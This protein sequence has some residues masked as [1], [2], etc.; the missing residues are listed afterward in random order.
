MKFCSGCGTALV[1]NLEKQRLECPKCGAEEPI[2]RNRLLEEPVFDK[3]AILYAGLDMDDRRR[4]KAYLD[5]LGHYA[6]WDVLRLDL[7]GEPLEPVTRRARCKLDPSMLKK[8]AEKY[9]IEPSK[10]E[11]LLED[12]TLD[13]SV[14]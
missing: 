9:G 12:L 11:R 8:T 2:E 14:Y 1:T 5:A 7:R 6:R 3:E 4:T 10:L 13:Q